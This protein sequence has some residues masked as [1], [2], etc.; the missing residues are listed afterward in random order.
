MGAN[1]VR[2]FGRVGCKDSFDL[3][4]FMQR[5]AVPFEWVELKSDEEARK[6]PGISSLTDRRLPVCELP[7]GVRLYNPRVRDLAEQLGFLA[8]PKLKEY[9]VSIYG[10]G[11]AGLSAAVYAA[12]DGLKTV[13]VER[14]AIGGQ[15]AAVR[16]SKTI[17]D[18]PKVFPAL[19][20]PTAR[21]SKP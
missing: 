20:W 5:S 6:L 4:D 12:S 13:L 8:K 16:S 7:T 21:G 18:F 19:T 15:A 11:P 10:A 1:L 2:L 9:D 3:R 17:S 14:A